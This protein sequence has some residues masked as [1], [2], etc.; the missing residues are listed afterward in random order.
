[1]ENILEW[2]L[3]VTTQ[4]HSASSISMLTFQENGQFD[5]CQ[6]LL[7]LSVALIGHIGCRTLCVEGQM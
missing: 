4:L 2:T 6:W 5:F 3:G 1:M 7:P